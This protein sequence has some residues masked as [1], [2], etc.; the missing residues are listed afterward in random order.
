[1][2]RR[3]VLLGALFVVLFALGWWAGRGRAAGD[4]YANL[5][6]FVEVLHAVQTAYVDEVEPKPLVEGAMNGMLHSLDAW[7]GYYDQ[8]S[9]DGLAAGLDGEI[10]GVGVWLDGHEGWPVVIAAVD[11]SPAAQAGLA[12]GDVIS[13]VDGRSTWNLSLAELGERLGG[14]EG[15]TVRLKLVRKDGDAEREVTVTRARFEVPAVRDVRVLDGGVG[16]LRVSLFSA[17]AA[18]GVRG[19][20]DT[21][22]ARGARSVIVDL[23]GNPGGLVDQAV[24]AAG[25]FVAPGATIATTRGRRAADART[26]ATPKGGAPVAWPMAVLVDAGTASAA[27]ILAGALQDL[28][29]A[30]VVGGNTYGKG[31]VQ[32]RFPLRNGAGGITLTTAWYATPSG[33]S[34]HRATPGADEADDAEDEDGPAPADSGVAAPADTPRPVFKTRAGRIVTGGGGVVPDLVAVADS[35]A[36]PGSRPAPER[37][38]VVLRAA[39]VLRRARTAADVFA[40]AAP[41]PGAPAPP[42]PDV[43]KLAPHGPRGSR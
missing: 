28:D 34:L 32:Q 18:A 24:A 23:R 2:I 11:G 5:D 39:E 27:E 36:A 4:L 1:M 7:S 6:L 14:A 20:L 31:A 22:R 21:L 26:L 30:L 17:R 38:P 16:Y 19:A 12:A 29:R 33:R 40:A 35:T 8:K 25:S 42:R 13:A 41:V 3:R 15:G 37:D 10:D 43:R 9:W